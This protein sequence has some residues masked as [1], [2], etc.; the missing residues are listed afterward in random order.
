MGSEKVD[1][2]SYVITGLWD[3][4][5]AAFE[6]LNT[7]TEGKDKKVYLTVA[8]DLVVRGITEPVRLLVETQ[9]RVY[10]QGERFWYFTRRPLVQPF[11]LNLK[12][13]S[14]WY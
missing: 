11:S 2:T 14:T 4:K 6:L 1:D 3:P 12:E 8:V 7:E 9:V 13:V 10:H 5:D